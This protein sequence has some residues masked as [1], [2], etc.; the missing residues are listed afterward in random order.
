MCNCTLALWEYGG[1]C[2]SSLFL[3]DITLPW[4]CTSHCNRGD[5]DSLK[6]FNSPVRKAQVCQVIEMTLNTLTARGKSDRSFPWG[7]SSHLPVPSGPAHCSGPKVQW[8]LW[9]QDP[10]ALSLHRTLGKNHDR[11]AQGEVLSCRAEAC[12]H[13]SQQVNLADFNT[14]P[15]SFRRR[16]TRSRALTALSSRWSAALCA[17]NQHRNNETQLLQEGRVLRGEKHGCAES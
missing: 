8:F 2:D 16:L 7:P 9:I 1:E 10:T 3:S 17:A 4:S 15:T 14:T 13:V 11:D 5:L 6:W 12:M